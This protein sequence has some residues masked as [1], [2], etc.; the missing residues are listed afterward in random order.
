MDAIAEYYHGDYPATVQAVLAGNNMLIVSDIEAA[1]TEIK[2]AVSAGLIDESRLDLV[3]APVIK[4]K[5]EKDLIT[6]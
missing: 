5:I 6:L 1:F 3:L 2:N 4:L